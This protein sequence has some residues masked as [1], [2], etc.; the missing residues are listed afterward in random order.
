MARSTHAGNG[1]LGAGL[2]SRAESARG[3]H[4]GCVSGPGGRVSST[5][6][7]SY[8][9]T[10]VEAAGVPTMPKRPGVVRDASVAAIIQFCGSAVTS[11]Q[12]FA[13]RFVPWRRKR[14]Q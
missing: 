7:E 4:R 8:W 1:T 2:K 6:K 9:V 12:A 10:F 13:Y 3:V 5:L 11:D 14:I